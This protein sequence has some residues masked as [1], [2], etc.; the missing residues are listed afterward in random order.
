[1]NMKIMMPRA[2]MSMVCLLRWGVALE[3]DFT[4]LSYLTD[5]NKPYNYSENGVIKGV[6][7][8]ALKAVLLH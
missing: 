7:V 1:M 4:T 5:E 8:D 2:I 6:G 3:A